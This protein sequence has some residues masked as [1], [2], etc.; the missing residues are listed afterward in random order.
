MISNGR[1]RTQYQ[2]LQLE[3]VNKVTTFNILGRGKPKIHKND[4]IP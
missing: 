3:I 1:K 2:I 4:N